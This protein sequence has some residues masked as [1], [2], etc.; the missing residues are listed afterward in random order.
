MRTKKR[1]TLCVARNNALIQR[2]AKVMVVLQRKGYHL[3]SALQILSSFCTAKGISVF[4]VGK[5]IVR[6]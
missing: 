1:V 2:D 6:R 4:K 3:S 5:D